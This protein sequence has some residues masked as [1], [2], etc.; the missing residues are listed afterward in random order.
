MAAAESCAQLLSPVMSQPQYPAPPPAYGAGPTPKPYR[1][2]DA[3]ATSPLLGS[4]RA[5]GSNAIFDQ[6]D[7]GDLPDD[8]KYGTTVSDSSPEIRLAFV[9]KVYSILCELQH[10]FV[11]GYG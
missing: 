7:E 6:P 9:R 10:L 1:D 11:L 3:G 2:N 4:P 8:F 5:G